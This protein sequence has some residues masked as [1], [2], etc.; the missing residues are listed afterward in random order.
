MTQTE[1]QRR[2]LALMR[3]AVP[4]VFLAVYGWCWYVMLDL[5][6]DVINGKYILTD[7]QIYSN[8]VLTCYVMDAYMLGIILLA[9]VLVRKCF[10]PDTFQSYKIRKLQEEVKR[11]DERIAVLEGQ[12]HIGDG[13]GGYTEVA[14]TE[15]KVVHV[16][17][18]H[19]DSDERDLDNSMRDSD[20]SC[21]AVCDGKGDP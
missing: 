8:A 9:F 2:A 10:A 21:P 5:T 17:E 4:W 3:K 16:C 14:G 20:I 15:E 18:D 1:K 7:D 11:L 19:A 6:A 13:L 12:G